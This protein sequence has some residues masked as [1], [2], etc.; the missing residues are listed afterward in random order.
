MR[1]LLDEQLSKAI[2]ATL[3]GRGLDVV[4]VTE[5]PELIELSDE[6]VLGIAATEGRAVATNNVK[7]FRPIAAERLR[8][9]TGHGGL[10]LL[11]SRIARTKAATGAL[12]DA[13]EAIMR[14]YPDGIEGSERWI[15]R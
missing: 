2:A 7:D 13:I 10:I 3:R 11:P 4:A 9:R 8:R 1:A 12:A 15:A 6:E 14:A 5:R